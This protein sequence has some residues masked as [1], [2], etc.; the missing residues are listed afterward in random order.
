MN[1]VPEFADDSAGPEASYYA[2]VMN[3]W[4]MKRLAAAKWGNYRIEAVLFLVGTFLAGVLKPQYQTR[5]LRGLQSATKR[6]ANNMD[7]VLRQQATPFVQMVDRLALKGLATRYSFMDVGEYTELLSSDVSEGMCVYWSET[8]ERAHIGAVTA[9]MRSRSW[10]LAAL[11][12]SEDKNALAFSASFRGLLESAA[13]TT[14]AFI[15]TPMTLA[16]YYPVITDALS[17]RAT[18]I[19]TSPELEDEL[20]HYSHGRY[21]KRSERATTP[22]FHQARSTHEYLKV[23]ENLNAEKVAQCYRFLC[24]LTHPGAP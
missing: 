20:I 7:S 9:I 12:A 21:I 14:T 3:I 10:L 17:G 16:H 11:S 18:T 6:E 15:G 22:Q 1:A 24:D 13:D 23:F 4:T 5:G 19:A 8:L 2:V